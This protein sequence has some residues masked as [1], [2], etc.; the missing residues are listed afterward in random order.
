MKP[1]ILPGKAIK[2]IDKTIGN[3]FWGHDSTTRKIHTLKWEEVAN[4]KGWEAWE[5][6]IHC[7]K[8]RQFFSVPCGESIAHPITFYPVPSLANIVPILIRKK[9]S[10]PSLTK[11][12]IEQLL[13]FFFF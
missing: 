1:F 7:I 9:P 5:L 13:F 12:L 11:A 10:L 4:V 6:S 3:F 8:I 2:S